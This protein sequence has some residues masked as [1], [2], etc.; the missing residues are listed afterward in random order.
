MPS[1]PS[2][3]TDASGVRPWA[4]DIDPKD[5]PTMITITRRQARRL[6]AVFRRHALGITHKG[7]VPPL[8]FRADPDTGL[9]V[10]HHQAALAVEHTLT[11]LYVTDEAVALPLD[12]LADF[13]GRD[14]SPVVLE[15]VGPG[16]TVARWEDRGI[17]RSKEYT[18]P[19]P[20]GLPPFPGQPAS[21][22]AC[23]GGLLDALAE[24]SATTDEGSTRYALDCIQLKGATGEVVA[25]DGRQILI[26]GGFTF[27]WDGDLLVRRTPLFSGRGLPRDRPVVVGRSD[28]HV[29]VRAGDW[30]AWMAVKA[31]ARFPR[32]EQA[33]PDPSAAATRLRLDPADAAFLARALDSLPGAD[34]A[35]SPAT[36]DLNGRVAVRARGAGQAA[37]TELV[38]CRSGYTGTPVMVNTNRAFLARAVR[39]GFDHV[40]FLDADSPVVCRDGNRVFCFQPLSKGSA[41]EP[42]D[43]VTR[44]ESTASTPR[45]VARPANVRRGEPPVHD[46][47]PKSGA[48]SQADGTTGRHAGTVEGP[49]P[50]GLAAL[51]REAGELHEAL[52]GAK[53]RAGR[54]VVAL[55]RQRK[56]A[57]LMTSTIAALKQLKLQDVAG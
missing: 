1:R 46:E 55:R 8:V 36:L 38:L 37:V 40:E 31:D 47:R 29:A 52:A 22:E 18:A 27:P 41:I 9:R 56:Q 17:P 50:V 15:A 53:A 21:F 20:A 4:P 16:R 6:R 30:T 39:L 28:A 7:L 24:A 3:T 19:D 35:N 33:I 10:R 5:T 11:G 32:I 25:T 43:D 12:A 45:P 44:V 14:G 42:S 49:G 48:P 23:P 26:Q 57:R 13:E 2:R 54:L 51:I 34:E